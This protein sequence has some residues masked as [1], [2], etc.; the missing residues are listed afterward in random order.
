MYKIDDQYRQWQLGELYYVERNPEW[1]CN[2]YRINN[3]EIRW[4]QTYPYLIDAFPLDPNEYFDTDGD[5]I[6]DFSDSDIDGDGYSNSIDQV[7]YDSRDYL[8]TDKDGIP[9]SIDPN[10]DNDN[11]LD[12]DEIGNGTDPLVFTPE[13]GGLDT[14]KDGISDP[15]E[16]SRGSDPETWDTDEDGVSDGWRYP[17]TCDHFEWFD[18]STWKD[19]FFRERSFDCGENW[20][21]FREGRVVWN[22]EDGGSVFMDMF[23]EDENEYWDTDGD[24]IGDNTDED[25]DGDG[26]SN[27][28]ELTPRSNGYTY[29]D[30]YTSFVC[31]EWWLL[32]P[33]SGSLPPPIL[34][35]VLPPIKIAV[36]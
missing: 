19:E 24:G 11:F 18:G 9:D 23:P 7:P 1:C 4:D 22:I 25:I 5:G 12:I 13:D 2:E 32:L 35:L 36:E 34:P 20:Y 27:E 29:W 26:V 3:G 30:E 6:G 33:P 10:K 8:D 16:L 28:K 21:Y 31:V 15:Y 17:S 14:D